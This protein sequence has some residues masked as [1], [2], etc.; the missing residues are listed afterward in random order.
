MLLFVSGICYSCSYKSDQSNAELITNL[1]GGDNNTSEQGKIVPNTSMDLEDISVMH[2]S[3]REAV[4][5]SSVT[6]NT[7]ESIRNESDQEGIPSVI[8][9]HLCGEVIQPGVYELAKGARVID[10]IKLAGG[11]SK[12]AA[13][14]YINQAQQVADGQRIYIPSKDEVKELPVMNELWLGD[15][16]QAEQV[17]KQ[18]ININLADAKDLME[19]PGVGEAKAASIIEYRNANGGFQT[20][21]ELMKIPGIKEGLFNKVSTYITVN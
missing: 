2:S 6:D 14:D 19:L 18:L 21:E 9:V 4:E 1:S 15:E 8:Y 16:V 20:I 7:E 11:L 12:E 17:S 13:G 3:G 5:G 10:L